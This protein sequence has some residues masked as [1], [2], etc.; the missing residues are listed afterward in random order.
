MGRDWGRNV[1]RPGDAEYNYACFCFWKG[2]LKEDHHAYVE[3]LAKTGKNRI[4]LHGIHSLR[5]QWQLEQCKWQPASE[6]LQ[7]AVHMARAVGRT[8]AVSETLL[9]LANF[10]LGRLQEPR[11]EINRLAKFRKPCHRGLAELWLA[12]GDRE[13][14]K[15][16]ALAAYK[17]A[18]ADGEPYVNRYELDKSRA[19]LEQ[20]GVEI[21]NLPPYDPEKEEKFPW[22]ADVVAAI[23]KLRA[24]KRAR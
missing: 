3:N 4:R 16:H 17:W 5:G 1:Y 11:Q 2:E 14:A 20:L 10:H 7:E 24:K 22:E 23:E 12:I 15:E 18:W 13:Q 21:P 19:L 9:A 6:S 8:D